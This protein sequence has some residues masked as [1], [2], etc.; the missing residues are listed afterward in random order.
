[1]NAVGLRLCVWLHRLHTSRAAKLPASG[2]TYPDLRGPGPI[3]GK[4]CRN[5]L[6]FV[7]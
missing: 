4:T 3:P 7:R 5:G 6:F 1:M 2:K